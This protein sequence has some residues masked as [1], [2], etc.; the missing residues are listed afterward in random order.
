MSRS[1]YRPPGVHWGTNPMWWNHLYAEV[2]NRRKVRKL[3][4]EVAK[5]ADPD[6][7]V[8]PQAKKPQSYYW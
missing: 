7:I 1:K 3:E 2:P 8:W 4:K 6:E 5:G